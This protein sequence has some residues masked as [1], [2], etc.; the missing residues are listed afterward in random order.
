MKVAIV[1]A[2][3]VGTTA[4]HALLD[5]GHAVSLHDPRGIAGGTSRG[6]A[7]WIAH[8]DV[9]PLASPKAWRNV[10]RWLADPLGPLAIRPAYAARLAPWLLRFLLAST[11]GRVAASTR[12][13][14]AL[15]LR[16]LPAWTRRLGTLGLGS[17][18]HEDGA[19]SV[20]TSEAAFAAAGALLRYQAESGIP[21]ERLDA[22]ATRALE[23]ALGPGIVGGALYATGARVSDPR[24]FTEALGEAAL[25]RGATLDTR[26]VQAIAPGPDGIALR[27]ADGTALRADR[28]V[29]AAGA[30]SKT[31]AAGLGHRVP[32][33][34]ERGY[35]VT[36][37]RGRLGLARQTVF[38]GHGFVTTPLDTGD[39]VGGAVEFGGLEA[40]PNFARVDA[41]LTRLQPFLPEA[42]LTGGERWMG[43]R[44]SIPDSLP[45]IGPARDPRVVLA[46]GHG[47]YGLTQ[48]AITAEIVAALVAGR[49]PPLDLSPFSPDRF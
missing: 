49:T 35:N 12:V 19:L 23:P 39:R 10:P 24:L 47:H 45:V 16:A 48:G 40:A 20:W 32:L 4:A 13:L 3:I 44:P 1:G 5:E 7:G 37:P 30:W 2:G 9:L 38:E 26:A 34:T 27:L 22:A 36:L 28:V 33:D 15:Q 42:D 29:L 31:L 8:M 14:T 18:L 43:F 46:F 6:N 41:I 17:H 11:P 21:V 25:G